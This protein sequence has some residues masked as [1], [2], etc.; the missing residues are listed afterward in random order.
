VFAATIATAVSTMEPRSLSFLER[1]AARGT[2][3]R[4]VVTPHRS[5]RAIS[6]FEEDEISRAA[7]SDFKSAG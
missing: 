4:E 5:L 2:I 1:V 7:S 3:Y 6:L